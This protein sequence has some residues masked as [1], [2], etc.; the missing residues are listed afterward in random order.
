LMPHPS[1]DDYLDFV[2]DKIDAKLH[3]SARAMQPNFN[4]RIY[5][6]VATQKALFQYDNAT[7]T[8][9]LLKTLIPTWQDHRAE[10][11]EQSASAYP[12]MITDINQLLRDPVTDRLV[13]LVKKNI[14]PYL[15]LDRIFKTEAPN[16]LNNILSSRPNLENKVWSIYQSWQTQTNSK[17]GTSIIRVII[18]IF[19]AKVLLGLLLEIPYDIIFAG[20]IDYLPLAVNTLF[21]PLLMIALTANIH[22]PK[23]NLEKLATMVNQIVYEDYVDQ[24][25]PTTVELTAHNSKRMSIIFNVVLTICYLALF[26]GVIYALVLLHFTLMSGFLFFLFFSVVSFFAVRLRQ[27]ANIYTV[28]KPKRDMLSGFIHFLAMPFMRVGQWLSATISQFNIILFILDLIIEAPFKAFFELFSQW[29]A[30]IKE[31]QDEIG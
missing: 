7:I 15:I 1:D 9:S 2:I 8:L 4:E 11:M 5:F 24:S 19:I 20:Q 21:P 31:K 16:Q 25:K 18:Y 26:G 17:L 13:K 14:A 3:I 28:T 6:Q 29:Q 12:T 23:G 30:F 22:T 27:S 10:S